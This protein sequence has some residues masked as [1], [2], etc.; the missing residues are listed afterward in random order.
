MGLV[1]RDGLLSME[2]MGLTSSSIDDILD[3]FV[4]DGKCCPIW[5]CVGD[6]VAEFA[7]D[8]MI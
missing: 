4:R 3:L 5:C 1:E 2:G 8:L 7:D 6:S